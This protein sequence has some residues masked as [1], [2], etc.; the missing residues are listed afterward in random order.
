[1]KKICL[2][3]PYKEFLTFDEEEKFIVKKFGNLSQVINIA[4]EFQKNG[5][6]IIIT[7]GGSA[8][9]LKENT[10]L[11]IIE[12]EISS[13]EII[14]T[15][16][17]ISNKDI[18]LGIVGYKNAVYKC[19]YLASIL[20]FKNIFEIIYDQYNNYSNYI[21]DLEHLI[22]NKKVTNFIGDTVLLNTLEK[23]TYYIN[24]YL[25]ESEY[26]SIH[27]A[28]NKAKIFL[29]YQEREKEKNFYYNLIL[30]NIDCG[31][32]LT[33]LEGKII[34]FNNVIRNFFYI[35][36]S[37][38]IF[39][40]FPTFKEFFIKNNSEIL[41]EI[42]NEKFII[43]FVN[44]E[45]KKSYIFI[46]RKIKN[47]ENL[48]N[49]SKK[50]KNN[51]SLYTWKNILTLNKRYL[52]ILEMAKVFAKTN[53]NVLITGESGTGK[54]LIAQS[55][56]SES[57]RQQY[58]FITFNCANITESLIE[59]ELFG[60][61]EGAFTG[62]VKKGKKGIFEL[63]NHG[64]IFLDEISEIPLHLQSKF[65]RVLEEKKFRKVGGEEYIFIDIRIIA[66]CNQDL[67]KL[68]QENKFRKDLFYRLSTLEIT[69]IPL[70]ER[71]EDIQH[72]GKFFLEKEL[73]AFP[74]FSIDNF[75]E[76][77][78]F[79]ETLSFSGNVRELKNI[80][81]KIVILKTS[82]NMSNKKIIEHILSAQ[83]KFSENQTYLNFENSKLRDIEKEIVTKIL[84]LENGNKSKTAIRLGID[85]GKIDRLLKN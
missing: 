43:S 3:A 39:N 42:N 41:L 74:N 5:G 56:H 78:T 62:A 22:F 53:E 34:E 40:I 82:L 35:E 2:L 1:M 71:K 63:A 73:V 19:S 11:K 52:E 9:I 4:Q 75:T 47:I 32:V 60:Y 10:S 17:K 31:I 37:Q 68:V 84:Q 55:I 51:K 20:G 27:N 49:I 77:L 23:R 76:L 14:K 44:T 29:E 85:R 36:K 15:L 57:F 38:N 69:T 70:N 30:N 16:Q 13:Y 18:P 59:S 26:S 80:I 21:N 61:T 54:E 50:I 79:I 58:P 8:Q 45:I 48:I 25:I 72:I 83:N 67:R 12:V 64:T 65:L 66:A 46:F 24:F 33:S 7:R 6:E 28:Y 81:K